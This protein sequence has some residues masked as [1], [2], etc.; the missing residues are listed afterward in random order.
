MILAQRERHSLADLLV[1]VGPDAPTLCEGWVTRD[2]L[3][4]LLMRESRMDA[5]VASAVPAL[6]GYANRVEQELLA[7]GYEAAVDRLRH[8]PAGLSPFRVPGADRAANTAEF[9]IHHEDVRRA[10]DVWEPRELSADEDALFAAARRMGRLTMRRHPRG[11]VLVVP[12][13]PRAKLRAGA[14]VDVVT[15]PPGELL[16]WVSGRQAHSRVH[17]TSGADL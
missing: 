6:S 12:D 8:G 16:M 13:G 10:Q 7:Q 1:T 4:H 2:L 5:A 11:V 17:V 14:Q 9:F 3:V 15:G